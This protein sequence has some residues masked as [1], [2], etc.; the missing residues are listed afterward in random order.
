MSNDVLQ[1]LEIKLGELMKKECSHRQNYYR[2]GGRGVIVCENLCNTVNLYIE[3]LNNNEI[4]NYNIKRD[5]ILNKCLSFLFGN[6]KSDR[7]NTFNGYRYNRAIMCIDKMNMQ[8]LKTT[9]TN[10]TTLCNIVPDNLLILLSSVRTQQCLMNIKKSSSISFSDTHFK[11]LKNLKIKITIQGLFEHILSLLDKTQENLVNMCFYFPEYTEKFMSDTCL[12]MGI[13]ELQTLCK[14]NNEVI[15]NII[16]KNKGGNR[17]NNICLQNA[18]LCGN[19]QLIEYLLDSRIVPESICL[20]NILKSHLHNSKRLKCIDMFISCDYKPTKMDII[21]CLHEGIIIEHINRFGV[22][23]DSEMTNICYKNGLNPKTYKLKHD[24]STLEFISQ[25]SLLSDIK[26]FIKTYNIVPNEQCL[27]NACTR[28]KV[29]VIRYLVSIGG[30]FTFK[31]MEKMMKHGTKSRA[32][33]GV[34][35]FR[36]YYHVMENEIKKIDEYKKKID[37][38]EIKLKKSNENIQSSKN[39]SDDESDDESDDDS[40]D[41]SDNESDGKNE[42]NED[43]FIEITVSNTIKIPKRQRQKVKPPFQ[44]V[45]Y[46]KLNDNKLSFIDSRQLLLKNIKDNNWFGKTKTHINLPEDFRKLLGISQNGSI[47]FTDLDKIVKLCYK[48]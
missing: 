10:I 35:F 17:L 32:S 38:L 33:T 4:E 40:D 21:K 36:P 30:N 34:D 39:K 47:N 48:K 13:N 46:F 22:T 14:N 26:K 18:S 2:R 3:Y 41:D 31:C 8:L 6:F 29:D 12:V 45:K 11:L 43:N 1:T 19:I 42:E 15:V 5:G 20:H 28:S 9:I 25:H 27:L 23:V 7:Y 16:K 37:E 24:I 44:M